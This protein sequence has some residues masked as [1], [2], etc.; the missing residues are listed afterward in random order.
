MVTVLGVGQMPEDGEEVGD[1]ARLFYV[2]AARRRR[3]CR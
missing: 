2:V 1:E 3:G